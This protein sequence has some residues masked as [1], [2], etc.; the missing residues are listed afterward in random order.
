MWRKPEYVRTKM[1][2]FLLAKLNVESL[3]PFAFNREVWTFFRTSLLFKWDS[4]PYNCIDWTNENVSFGARN[5]ECLSKKCSL[6]ISIVFVKNNG[7][8][9]SG[10]HLPDTQVAKLFLLSWLDDVT[11]PSCPN[12]L[13]CSR[14]YLNFVMA[15]GR[16]QKLSLN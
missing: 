15:G 14:P 9:L 11:S 10:T 5:Y 13:S 3:L 12:F 1:S 7:K 2:C 16:S 6:R 4:F 8:N